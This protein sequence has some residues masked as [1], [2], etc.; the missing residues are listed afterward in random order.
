VR[1]P[2][3]SCLLCSKPLYRRPYEL[4]RRR[5]A[6]CMKCRSEA[7]KVAGITD[8]QQTGLS[9]G[10][11][12]GTNHRTGYTHRDESRAKVAASNAAYWAANPESAKARGAKL[13]GPA[14]YRWNGGSSRLNISVRT[15]TE[16]R[17]WMDAVRKRDE[18]C[19][20][21]RSVD[22]LEA[23]HLVPLSQLI[24]SLEIRNRDDA[25]RNAD[26]LWN[27]G[28]GLTLCRPCHFEEHGRGA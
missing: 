11:M 14:H 24:Q 9:M 18:H 17:R 16:N 8:K 26:V 4:A 15:M 19:K 10:R 20:R 7:Q 5:Y 21:C 28:N 27:L 2:N 22:A 3:T 1:T 6:A 23:H 25:R 12:K 13:R